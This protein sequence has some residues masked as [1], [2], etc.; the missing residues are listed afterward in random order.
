MKATKKDYS[1]DLKTA[2][3]FIVVGLVIAMLS[4][5][6]MFQIE[7][8]PDESELLRI[9]GV[10][11]EKKIKNQR[12]GAQQFELTLSGF[13]GKLI[14][15]D[16]AFKKACDH[17]LDLMVGDSV[18]LGYHDKG[19]FGYVVYS[20]RSHQKDILKYEDLVLA[21]RDNNHKFIFLF[22]TLGALSIVCGIWMK[23][24]IQASFNI[25]GK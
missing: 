10:L 9:H 6:P 1:K 2:R 18:S 5:Y 22:F 11:I 19:I 24:K 12:K 7:N 20:I 3:G 4:L 13:P 16:L 17:C 21:S 14:V 8:F 23:R 25:A 15:T